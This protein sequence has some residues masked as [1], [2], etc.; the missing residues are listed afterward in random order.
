M[1]SRRRSRVDEVGDLLELRGA[2]RSRPTEGRTSLLVRLRRQPSRLVEPV[3]A[4]VGELAVT[5][6]ASPRLAEGVV[7]TRH[8]EDVVDDLKQDPELGREL[9]KRSKC[10][11]SFISALQQQYALHG[12]PDQPSRLEAVQLP[13]RDVT[14]QHEILDVDVLTADHPR[15]A[16]GGRELPDG[17]EDVARLAGLV[18]QHEPE[19]LCVQAVPGED[20]HVFAELAV[21]GRTP[22]AKVVVVHGGQVVVDEGIRV[23]ELERRGER[24]HGRRVRS[25][26]PCSGQ[27]EDGANAL[28]AGQQ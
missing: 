9:A 1:E 2:V 19:R 11:C 20:G 24:Q 6:V 14:R 5:L 10:R 22:A 27:R 7:R 28:A 12:R 23:D 25:D 18:D 8:V 3:L 13:Q 21:T 16:R 17:G 4:D 26:G 15:H